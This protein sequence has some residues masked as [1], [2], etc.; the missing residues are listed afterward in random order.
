MFSFV[1]IYSLFVTQLT[2]KDLKKIIARRDKRYDGRFYFGVKTTKIYCRPVCPA[3]PKPENIVIFKSASEAERNGFRPCLRCR[4]DVAP[5]SVLFNGTLNTVSRALKIIGSSVDNDVSIDDL[6]RRLGISARHL[7]RLFDDHL[8]ASPIEII[9]TQRLHFAKQLVQS[10]NVSVTE[11]AFA[12]GFQSIR[13]F[14]EAFKKRFHIAPSAF[15]KMRGSNVE[16]RL[17]LKIPI[18]LP[19][20]WK[21][22]L[23]YLAR[24]ECYGIER[25]ESDKFYRFVPIKNG[26]GT[27]VV[28]REGKESFLTVDFDKVPLQEV[29]A[30]LARIKILFDTDHNPADL[31]ESRKLRINGIRAPGSFD[32]FE[33]AISII[34]SQ[35]VSTQHAKYK[36]KQLVQQFGIPLGKNHF[37]DVHAFPTPDTLSKAKIEELGVT[38]I[39]AHAIRTFSEAIKN[40]T[41]SFHSHEDFSLILKKLIEIKGIGV[42]TGA[43]MMMRCFG[44]P[45]A[46][47][48]FDLI[49]RRAIEKKFARPGNWI[50]S[51]AY[52]TH[53]LWRD[54]G[55]ALSKTKK[56]R[57]DVSIRATI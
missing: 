41:I 35:L 57:I 53:Y 23:S 19:Y 51:R 40:K 44:N 13:R 50:S 45:D 5:G 21:Y 2:D 34:L 30:I 27:V 1:L 4:P 49:V 3:K 37:S 22:V 55:E 6:A 29:K 15:R 25:V 14:N 39:K 11:I 28:S 32:P 52:L 43:M 48:E 8:G 38:K 54:Y 46:F 10:T 7:R 18:H 17:S 24:H 16:S 47:P 31:P 36:L 42:W 56:R 20:D 9:L 12:S 33:V 26:F